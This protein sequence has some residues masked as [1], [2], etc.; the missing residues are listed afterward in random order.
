[1]TKTPPFA[2]DLSEA[3]T[4]W[5]E[6]RTKFK[7]PAHASQAQASEHTPNLHGAWLDA[8]LHARGWR[9]NPDKVH[10]YTDERAYELHPH[11]LSELEQIRHML[12]VVNDPE[13]IVEAVRENI[14]R[15]HAATNAIERFSKEDQKPIPMRLLCPECFKLHIDVGE[16]EVKLHHTHA[17]QFCGMVWRPALVPTVGVK[18]LPGFRNDAP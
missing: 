17:C 15:L 14:N 8:F 18:F 12:N 10:E 5:E 9:L 11:P 3:Q 16:F 7:I 13:A 4:L 1:M 2:L 6:Y